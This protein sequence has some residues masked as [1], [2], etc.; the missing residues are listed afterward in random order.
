MVAVLLAHGRAGGVEAVRPEDQ[1]LVVA[2]RGLDR[3]RARLDRLCMLPLDRGL[4]GPA[5]DPGAPA[6]TAGGD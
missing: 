5:S 2:V 6:R 1:V 3:A 4:H